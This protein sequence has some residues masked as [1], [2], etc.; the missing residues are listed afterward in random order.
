MQRLEVSGA[1]RH[2]YMSLGGKGL[3]LFDFPKHGFPL[4]V[5]S[6]AFIVIDFF[7][8]LSLTVFYVTFRPHSDMQF[9]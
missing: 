4:L 3:M 8:F 6:F 1:V 7:F 5:V 9:Q 2:M